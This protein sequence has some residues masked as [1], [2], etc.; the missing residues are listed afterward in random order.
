MGQ[1]DDQPSDEQLYAAWRAGDDLAGRR[2]VA[3]RMPGTQRF[4]ASL[5]G[6][7]ERDDALQ[8]VFERLARHAREGRELS[9]VRAF[10]AGIARNVVHEHLRG[11][12]RKEID[13]ATHSLV[14]IRPT[15]SAEIVRHEQ[16]RL[17]LK[18]LHR[19][20]I[21]DQILLGLRY[22]ERLRTREL[23]DILGV[24]HSTLRTRLQ[25]A[26]ARLLA[27]IEQLADSPEAVRSTIGSLGGWAREVGERIKR[28]DSD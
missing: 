17:L 3:R 28:D 24:N 13:V 5:L 8:E 19:L 18:S 6:G 16:Q 4:I 21:D 11:P 12:A 10:I 14:D 1:A 20:P 15:Q 22:W 27:I 7:S 9:N 2:L 23:A 26:E 25:R